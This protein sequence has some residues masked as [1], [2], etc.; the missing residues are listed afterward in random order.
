MT[1]ATR[2]PAQ[3]LN[4]IA[5][6]LGITRQTLA[7]YRD[8]GAPLHDLWALDEWVAAHRATVAAGRITGMRAKP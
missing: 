8:L 2:R 5:R 1:S 4:L 7:T 6:R 3:P